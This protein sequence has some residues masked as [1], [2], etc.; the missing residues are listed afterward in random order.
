MLQAV[1]EQHGSVQIG[2]WNVVSVPDGAPAPSKSADG[3]AAAAPAAGGD[4][5]FSYL[6]NCKELLQSFEYAKEVCPPPALPQ[7]EKQAA[8]PPT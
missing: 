8:K 3:T 4:R 2:L 5:K 6:N 7:L 1:S